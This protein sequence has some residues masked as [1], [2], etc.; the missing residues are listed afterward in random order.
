MLY[1]LCLLLLLMTLLKDYVFEYFE[2]APIFITGDI[3]EQVIAFQVLYKLL[4]AFIA[5][6][7]R[8]QEQ[9]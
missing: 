6:D 8:H 9:L 1:Q 4:V 5:K 2:N 3:A 7:G